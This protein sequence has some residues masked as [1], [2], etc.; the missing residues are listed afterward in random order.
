M[1][2]NLLFVSLGSVVGG[3][4][5]YLVSLLTSNYYIGKFPIATFSVNLIGSF[6]IGILFGMI[7]KN[8]IFSEQIRLIL[9]VGFCGGFTTFSSF[10]LETMNLL[11]DNDFMIAFAYVSSSII[12]G[13]LLTILGK[14]IAN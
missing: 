2:K 9:I 12:L 8:H 11:R 4:S 5:R 1:I 7:D 10:S 13:L 6:I 3:L 14:T